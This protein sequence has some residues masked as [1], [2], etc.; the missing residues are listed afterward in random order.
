MEPINNEQLLEKLKKA[1]E[2][3]RSAY[4]IASRGG[5]DTNWEPFSKSVL[6]ELEKQQEIIYSGLQSN[7]RKD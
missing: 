6:E 7:Q 4:S 2:L 5:S 3:L 1:N